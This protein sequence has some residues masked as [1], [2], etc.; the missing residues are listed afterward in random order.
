MLDNKVKN[1]YIEKMELLPDEMSILVGKS[2]CFYILSQLTIRG[3][4]ADLLDMVNDY[5]S[6]IRRNNRP[7]AYVPRYVTMSV[8][9]VKK[10][11]FVCDVANF[12]FVLPQNYDEAVNYFVSEKL[13]VLKNKLELLIIDNK[14]NEAFK[15]IDNIEDIYLKKL[16]LIYV[17]YIHNMET[18]R[19]IMNINISRKKIISQ[20]DAILY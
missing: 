1:E 16:S 5:I 9:D 2:W 10:L 12:N 7:L 18:E 19:K 3:D 6:T 17:K 8:G 14:I 11:S 20:I 13:G 4:R 15:L